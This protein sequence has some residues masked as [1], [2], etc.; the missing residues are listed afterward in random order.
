[1]AQ[2]PNDNSGTGVILGI[3]V[4]A[5]IAV[6]GYYFLKSEGAID[7]AG[8]TANI[9]MPDVNIAPAAGEPAKE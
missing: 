3:L 2:Q 9:E 5:L 1:M 7:G 4:A 6:G 8:T